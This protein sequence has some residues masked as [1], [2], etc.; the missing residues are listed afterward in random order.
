MSTQTTRLDLIRHGEPVGGRR[1]RGDAVDDPL[2]DTGWQQLESRLR[3]LEARA[4]PT[5]T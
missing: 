3:R 5:G 2:S 1:F 4:W